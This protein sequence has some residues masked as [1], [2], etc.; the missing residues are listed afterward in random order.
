MEEKIMAEMVSRIDPKVLKVH[1]RNAEF[2]D[3]VDGAE[4]DRL[5][6]SIKDH[7]VLTPLRVTKD[8]TIISGHQRVRAA[9][10]AGCSDVPVIF[11]E[12][13]DENDVLMKLIETNF[14]RMKNDKVKQAKWLDEYMRLKGVRQG[15]AGKRSLEGNNSP[16]KQEDI[17]KELGVDVTTLKNLKSL[18]KL[19]PA[20]Q[21][22]VSE[23]KISATTGFKVLA[24]LSPE[25]QTK[26]YG[27]LPTDVKLSDKAV[28]AYVEELQQKADEDRQ[29]AVNNTNKAMEENS[30]LMGENDKLSRE[31]ETLRA[32]GASPEVQE[33]LKQLESERQK[34][35]DNLEEVKK[36][37]D[38]LRK[39]LKEYFDRNQELENAMKGGDSEAI[40][41]QNEIDELR[42]ELEA[43]ERKA[44][45]LEYQLEEKD[46]EI[47][48][49]KRE[50]KEGFMR[51]ALRIDET[52]E[53]LSQRE[54]D[55]LVSNIQIAIGQFQ[56]KVEGALTQLDS[57]YSID[58][59]ILK[60]LVETCSQAISV[61]TRLKVA[62]MTASGFD[63]EVTGN[64]DYDLDDSGLELTL[65]A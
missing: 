30:R 12:S 36:T 25:E 43:R 6:E 34:V 9:I 17:A 63:D 55:A 33:K 54:R 20:F 32:G 11:D 35:S 51:K 59:S 50:S 10:Q 64:E 31:N 49:L 45:D 37:N 19:D 14:G 52:P 16:L 27:K 8:M 1:P 24:K 15:S 47:K 65:G 62:L 3:D 61:G 40:K 42:K 58:K 29:K 7:G 41:L 22:L 46:D 5:V 44:N 21:A 28:R 18:L 26:L 23:G 2:F 13:D 48:E 57:F 60:V 39:M 56:S 4:F 53:E 38:G